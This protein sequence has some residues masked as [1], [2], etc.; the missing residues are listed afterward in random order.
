MSQPTSVVVSTIAEN[1]TP[2]AAKPEEGKGVVQRR[3]T[4]VRGIASV[5]LEQALGVLRNPCP[6]QRHIYFGMVAS[7]P[8]TIEA[9][10]AEVS[11]PMQNITGAQRTALMQVLEQY[12]RHIDWEA[13]RCMD[14]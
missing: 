6:R 12:E 11:Q 14:A 4:I 5:T 13:L 10:R 3:A 1:E 2:P 7:S 9:L 8:S